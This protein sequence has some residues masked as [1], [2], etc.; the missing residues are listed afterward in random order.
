M[1]ENVRGSRK[2]AQRPPKQKMELCWKIK[3]FLFIIARQTELDLGTELE[4]DGNTFFLPC[5]CNKS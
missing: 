4:K 3:I 1:N 2:V 5:E